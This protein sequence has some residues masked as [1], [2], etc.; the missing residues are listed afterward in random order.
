MTN[1]LI[2]VVILL[3]VITLVQ[4]LRVGDLLSEIKNVDNNKVTDKDNN[5]QAFLFFMIGGVIYL[6]LVLWQFKYW[7][8][9]ILPPASSL[10]GA[11]IDTLMQV[12]CALILFVFFI[13]QPI[14]AWFTY[15]YRGNS[16]NKSLLLCSQQ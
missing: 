2:I 8:I 16:K 9:H 7:G 13:T 3:I 14:L 6:A 12:T 1:I 11:T 4:L 10:H 5:T 15:K